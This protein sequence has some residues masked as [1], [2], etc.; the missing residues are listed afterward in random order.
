MRFLRFYKSNIAEGR[1]ILFFSILVAIVVRLIFYFSIKDTTSAVS[2][3]YL[4]QPLTPL[5]ADPLI[6]LIGSSTLVAG[7][8]LLVAH[9]NTAHVLI[10]RRTMLPPSII[11]LLF[12]CHPMFM[13]MSP[14]YIAVLCMLFVINILFTA[15]NASE[16]AVGAFRVAFVLSLGSLFAPVMLVYIPLSWVALGIMRSLNFKSFLAAILGALIIYFPA[17]SFYIFSDQLDLFLKPFLSIL[18]V[19]TLPLFQFDFILWGGLSFFLILLSLIIG[20]NYINSYKDKIKTRAFLSSLSFIT[21]TAIL[22]LLLLNINPD[23]NLYIAIGVG[24][25]LLSHFFALVERRGG[26][27]LFYI[28][29]LL[30]LA[31]STLS[32]YEFYNP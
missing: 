31:T 14:S 6:S 8:A 15:Y 22:L 30:L 23:V 20:D 27:I 19:N 29:I 21:I 1:G 12:S 32:F 13:Q 25:L 18:D 5:L 2:D 4:W 26:A 24:S 11:A 10:R 9:I 7:I 28:F 3:G 16:K 17:F